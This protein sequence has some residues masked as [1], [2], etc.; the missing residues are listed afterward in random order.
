MMPSVALPKLTGST[1]GRI[2]RVVLAS[3]L[4]L[5]GAHV[6]AQVGPQQGGSEM[7]VWTAGGHSVSGGRGNT[8]IFDVGLRYGWVLLDSHGPSFL[9]GRFEYAID[10]VPMYLIFQP[11][12]TAYG[13]GLNPLN[14]KWNFERHGRIVPYTELSG[15][16]LFT[17]HDVPA[18]TSQINFT[19]SAGFGFHYL[20]DRFAWTLEGR[21]LH[22]SDAGLSRLNPGVNTFEVRIGVG[23]F[24]K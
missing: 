17:T 21:Y 4:L 14:L 15:G 6:L 10:A 18:N 23:K 5:C 22:I 13:V 20:A 2:S 12:N 7:Q 3:L 8:G 11:T 19:P 16:L 1:F 24:R 9:K